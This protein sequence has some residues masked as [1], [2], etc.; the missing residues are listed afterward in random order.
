MGASGRSM[1]KIRYT[2]PELLDRHLAEMP[3]APAL[4]D[5]DT[6]ISY[7]AFD[8]LCRRTAGWLA[9]QG[10]RPGDRVAVWLINRLE[11]L[12]LLFGL[13]RLGATLIAVNT[14]FRAAELEHVIERCEPRMLVFQ[15]RFRQADFGAVLRELHPQA[16]HS[17]GRIVA[18]GAEGG[19]DVQGQACVAFDAFTAE[20]PEAPDRSHPDAIA[21]M[22]TTSGTTKG[23]KLVMHAQ[24]SIAAHVRSVAGAFSINPQARVLAALPFCGVFG[25][26]LVLGAL[27]G[28]A[29]AIL[30][31]AFEA[32]SAAEKIVR[33]GVTHVC[34]SDEMA[35]RLVECASGDHPFPSLQIFGFAA[36]QP[37]SAELARIAW[38][39]R[40]PLVGLYGSS[41]VQALFAFQ[42]LD[43][44]LEARV[45]PGGLPV[46][47]PGAEVRIRDIENGELAPVGTSGEIEIR[48]PSMFAGYC[49]DHEA[50]S[51]AIGSDGFL[52]TGDIGRLRPD[53][54]FVF[55]TR[56]G[57]ALRLGGFL[58]S[59]AEI[60]D[61]LKGI[62][63]VA[64]AQVVAIELDGRTRPV[65]FVI[66][67]PG[68]HLSEAEVVARS[69][70]RMAAFKVPARVWFLDSFPM[71]ESANGTKIQRAR[72][73][74]I[75]ME[76]LG[77]FHAA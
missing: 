68:V 43:L 34:G 18:V 5:G 64:D 16:V 39:R 2:L 47:G 51:A 67:K 9:A 48:A 46:A 6:A 76:R 26:D 24:R 27:A 36:F 10:I 71:T 13:A 72:L 44:A 1:N 38:Q 15:P 12:A 11:W 40:I 25:L 63:D 50:T 21:A 60:E 55:E 4:I 7:A 54:T 31:E 69:S 41:E 53:G 70:G 74:E 33:H 29:P 58:V 22:F 20:F 37:G 42:P 59:P 62:P 77:A 75:A 49:N 61:A 45:E 65:A 8:G 66:P 17:I 19:L 73:R 28:G 57:D 52:R 35:R 30:M 56:R 3:D 32:T 23:P 14:R